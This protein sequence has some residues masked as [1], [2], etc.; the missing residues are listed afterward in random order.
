VLSGGAVKRIADSVLVEMVTTD[1][2]QASEDAKKCPKLRQLAIAP[3]IGEAVMSIAT[4]RSV[5]RLFN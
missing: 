5:S 2:I 3:L 1:T 4:E